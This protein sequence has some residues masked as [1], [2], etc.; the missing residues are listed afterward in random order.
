[1]QLTAKRWSLERYRELTERLVHELN[2]EVLLIGGSDDA[3]LNAQLLDSLHVPDGSV[4]NLAGKTTIGELAAQLERCGLFIGN[5][6]SPM[7]LAAALDIPVIAIF[8]PTS[9]Q[10]YG[11]YPLDDPRHVALWK[12]PHGQPCFFLGVRCVFAPTAP[13]CKQSAWMMYGMLFNA[14]FPSLTAK[15]SAVN[16][17]KLLFRRIMLLLVRLYGFTGVQKAAKQQQTLPAAPRILLI[18]PDHLGDMVLTTPVLDALKTHLPQAHITMMVGP[19]LSEVIARH[20][21][22]DASADLPI[23][24]LSTHGAKGIDTL[25]NAI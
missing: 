16:S 9:P 23:S 6:S 13:V 11:P 22:I 17:V 14:L 10:E 20:L 15:R 12:N 1:M 5:D 2:T 19:W 4:I 24:W 8:G 18:R 21:A 3:A 7:H 25:Y